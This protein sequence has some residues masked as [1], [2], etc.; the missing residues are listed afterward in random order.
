MEDRKMELKRDADMIV[1]YLTLRRCIGIL[2]MALPF[3]VMLGGLLQSPL[4][5][6]SSISDYYYTNMRDF[7]VGLMCAVGLFLIT[8][9]G[10]DDVDNGVSIASGILAFGVAAFPTF[11]PTGESVRV[12]IFLLDDNVS[13]Y[14]HLT[15]ACLFFVLLA[16]NSIFLFTK[17][18]DKPVTARKRTRNAVYVICGV[19][20]LAS[21]AI[22]AAYVA[23]LQ[24]TPVARLKPVLVL[25]TLMLAAFGFSWL[26][27][28]ETLFRDR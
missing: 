26:V 14:F 22:L 10:Y 24:D 9:K 20:M 18:D 13:K 5:I 12:G 6:Q 19:V 25:E 17:S 2:G 21:I 27:K 16:I 8:Y 7:F 1:S 11:T 4:R 23:F 15:C 28:G 3:A